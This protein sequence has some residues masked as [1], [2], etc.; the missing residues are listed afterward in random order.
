MPR[1]SLP[2]QTRM[3]AMRSRWFGS[4]FAWI[5]KTKPDMLRLG[6]LDHALVGLLGARRRRIGG[7]RIEQI[8]HAE[9]LERAAEVDRRQMCPRGRPRDRR[10]AGLTSSTSSRQRRGVCP[11]GSSVV[12]DGSSGP[13][14]PPASARSSL[15]ER[16]NACWLEIVGADEI[17]AAAD[18]PG[19][20]RRVERQ[21]LLDLVEQLEGVAALAVHLVDEGD[22]RDVAQAADLEQL[23]RARLDA[24]GGVDH[25][26]RGVDRGQ[27]A[28]GVFREVL[29]ARRVEQVEDR[30]PYTRRSS[31]R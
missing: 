10:L 11:C 22:D 17:A 14:R 26:D 30:S 23:A 5:L 29:V 12:D 31:P 15:V 6:R 18:R 24:L 19:H 27:R 8:A 2:E 9:I 7:E 20:G 21:R 16:R 4:M 25:H 1:V 28:V 13:R 3:K